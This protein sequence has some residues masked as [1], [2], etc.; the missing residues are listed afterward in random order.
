MLLEATTVN[1]QLSSKLIAGAAAAESKSNQIKILS[2]MGGLENDVY[3][4]LDKKGAQWK[5]IEDI[6]S[7]KKLEE[8]CNNPELMVQI[9]G[10][11]VIFLCLGLKDIEEMEVNCL[12]LAQRY[13]KCVDIMSEILGSAIIVLKLPPARQTL[14]LSDVIVFNGALKSYDNIT[15]I[16]SAELKNMIRSKIY[17][18]DGNLSDVAAK[19]IA[20]IINEMSLPDTNPT[21]MK[22]VEAKINEK[23]KLTMKLDLKSAP[24]PAPIDEPPLKDNEFGDFV[25]IENDK[26]GPVIGKG[27]RNLNYIQ[28]TTK[29]TVKM[30]Y[31]D[32]LSGSEVSG[33]FIK[34]TDEN[35]VEKARRMIKARLDSDKRKP[36]GATGVSPLAKKGRN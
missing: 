36:D 10:Y 26:W 3:V 32:P 35:A 31:R 19:A 18:I 8:V 15:V 11:N 21:D 14:N 5:K 12:D 13:K 34:G 7:V 1:D 24:E 20:G 30:M 29:T 22:V 27:G 25:N 23:L 33:A 4:H 17:T 9:S 28:N 16:E 2:L 6:K